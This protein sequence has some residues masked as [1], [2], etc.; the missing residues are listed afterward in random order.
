MGILLEHFPVS[1]QLGLLAIV[2]ALFGGISLGLIGA[3]KPNSLLDNLTTFLSVIGVSTPN[4]VAATLMMILFAVWL[5]WLPTGGWDGIWST[6]IIMPVIALGLGPM[7]IIARY[8][9]SAVIESMSQDYVRTA[10]AKGMSERYVFI[11]HVL[12][13]AMMSV[14]TVAGISLVEVVTGSFFVESILNVPGIGRYFVTSVTGRDYPVI[15]GTTLLYATLVVI[16]NL[17]VDIM[18]TLLDPRI[19]YR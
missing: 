6:R 13:N 2:F 19:R 9:R 7:A 17:V 15:I 14:V 1:L 4:Y 11:R 18:Y 8:T 10:R 12:P 5:G 16:M 3:V